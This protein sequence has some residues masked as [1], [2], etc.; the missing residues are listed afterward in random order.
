MA[1]AAKTW[2]SAGKRWEAG[3]GIAWDS[4]A[5][6]PELNQY[7]KELFGHDNAWCQ[8]QPAR[9]PC[10]LAIIESVKSLAV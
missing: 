6:D 9:P 5:F 1:L 2:D 8:C 7:Q 4:F 10:E 3:G